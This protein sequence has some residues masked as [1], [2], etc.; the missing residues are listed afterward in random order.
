MRLID[1]DAFIEYANNRQDLFADELTGMIN[2]QQTAY[3]VENVVAELEEAKDGI[4]LNEDD[5][6][7]YCGALD[8]AIDIV[9]RGGVE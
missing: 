7:I 4:A 3:D 6:N 2:E 9:K 5:L 1:A 8:D